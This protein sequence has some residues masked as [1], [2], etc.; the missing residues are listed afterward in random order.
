MRV[1]AG[2]AKGRPLKCPPGRQVRPTPDMV[3][4]SLFAILGERVLGCRFLDLYAG[5]GAV[6]IEAASRGAARV[7]FVEKT[8]SIVEYLQRNLSGTGMEERARVLRA[9][10]ERACHRLA[11]TGE[12][13]D[14]VFLGPPYSLLTERAVAAAA[15]V[16]APDG[17]LVVQH[18]SRRQA[19]VPAG[20]QLLS[21]RRY[22]DNTISFLTSSAGGRA[23]A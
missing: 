4:E 8:P 18:P 7:T 15:K 11:R 16:L 3:R 21:A 5:T 10:A 9:D 17:V 13:F 2:E 6:G 23:D 19:P 14:I 1:I 22:G 12:R 20:L